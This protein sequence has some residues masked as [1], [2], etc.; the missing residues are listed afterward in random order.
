MGHAELAYNLRRRPLLLQADVAAIAT[1]LNM[2]LPSFASV[3]EW[4]SLELWTE[5]LLLLD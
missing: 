5:S 4:S 3:C 2:P 1:A